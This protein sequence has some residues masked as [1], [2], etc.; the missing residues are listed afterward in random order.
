[1]KRIFTFLFCVFLALGL[2]ATNAV[3]TGTLTLVSGTTY[4][5][6]YIHDTIGNFTMGK[7]AGA[8]WYL[9]GLNFPV[10]TAASD[11][12]IRFYDANNKFINISGFD[13]TGCTTGISIESGTSFCLS[14]NKIHNNSSA[15]ITI[16]TTGSTVSYNV[17]YANGGSGIRDYCAAGGTLSIF[18]N[19]TYGNMSFGISVGELAAS[20]VA[21]KNNISSSNGS[22]ELCLQHGSTLTDSNNS[23]DGGYFG[24]W[25]KTNN[26]DLA[27]QFV[28]A[29]GGDFRL[30]ATS[31]L[32][33]KGV[34]ISGL[35]TDV[36][37]NSVPA[38][39]GKAPD[40]GAYENRPGGVFIF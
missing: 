2:S 18:N 26:V 12:G 35:T 40:I 37:G 7:H 16:F 9:H 14:G 31:P 3:T 23:N 17:S 30:K 36:A 15:G 28:N 20:V 38:Y 32:L 6:I 27:P 24:T 34:A 13:I 39:T 21:V 8:Y 33:R 5:K 4:T 1:M 11:I 29:A 25:A 19:V 10:V 22:H